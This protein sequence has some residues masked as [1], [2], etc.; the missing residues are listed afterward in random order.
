MRWSLFLASF[1]L[2]GATPVSFPSTIILAPAGL[3]VT[4]TFWEVPRT[5][6]AQLCRKNRHAVA[7]AHHVFHFA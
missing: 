3:L 7:T 1:N 4:G 2:N 6:V 5:M